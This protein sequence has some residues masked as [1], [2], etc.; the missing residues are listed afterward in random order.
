MQIRKKPKL[1]VKQQFNNNYHDVLFLYVQLT[2]NSALN[3]VTKSDNSPPRRPRPYVAQAK[4]KLD[5][6]PSFCTDFE[7]TAQAAAMCSVSLRS[8]PYRAKLCARAPMKASP[9]PVVSTTCSGGTC[10]AGTCSNSPG[11]CSRL[12][13]TAPSLPNVMITVLAPSS[14]RRLIAALA[15]L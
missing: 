4:G 3:I 14:K 5:W 8:V 13:H 10:G 11:D 7:A 2:T 12:A 1:T 9:A 15:S 6:V